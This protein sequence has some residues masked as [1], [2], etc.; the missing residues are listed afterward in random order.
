MIG[1]ESLAFDG[2]EL[3]LIVD[4]LASPAFSGTL[5]LTL[6]PGMTDTARRLLDRTNGLHFR[7]LKLL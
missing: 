2:H 1:F 4:P 3:P 5:E 7:R 6:Y